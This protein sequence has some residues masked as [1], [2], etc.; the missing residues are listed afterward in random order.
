MVASAPCGR[1]RRVSSPTGRH[2]APPLLLVHGL[3]TTSYSWRYLLG[4]L[5]G[6][7][8]VQRSSHVVQ[9]DSPDRLAALLVDFLER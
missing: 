2:D 1:L 7:F 8:W 4:R 5:G 6:R 3:M 9:V